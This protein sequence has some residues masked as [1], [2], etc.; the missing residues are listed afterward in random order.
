MRTMRRV[1]VHN[2]GPRPSRQVRAIL[3]ATRH[4]GSETASDPG[5]PCRPAYLA[6]HR[7][8]ELLE[9]A[10][11]MWSMM[12]KCRLC[13][14]ECGAN[15]LQGKR[16]FCG[17]T[18]TTLTVSS[19]HPHFG[20]ERPLVGTNG[21]GTIFFSHC[22]LR[23]VFCQNWEISMQGCGAERSVEDLAGMMLWLQ[24]IGCHNI[25]LVTPTHYSAH[26][27]KALDLAA[28][29]DLRLPVVY[30][31]SGWERLEILKL[32]DGI[33]DIY[34][35]DFK[36]WDSG[37]ASTYS[38]GADSYPGVTAE[39]IVEMQRQIGSP[40]Y[41]AEGVMQRG[42]I[43]RHLVMPNTVSGSEQIMEW[44][45]KNMKKDIYINIMAQYRPEYKAH[46]YPDIAR[47][48]TMAEYA[49]VVEKARKLGL[50]NL[51][52]HTASLMQF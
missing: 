20:E 26:I 41:T 14:R 31:T 44:I 35:P 45:A 17:T 25:N 10:R 30:N 21:S 15:R 6:L 23:C 32:L 27:L 50:T 22:S 9:R 19:F 2:S 29:R 1:N 46:Q 49:S 28:G 8:G 4:S 34:M 43:V 33:V 52:V 38:S 12:G 24:R 5:P 51:D 13:P 36:Y 7:S 16:G 37:M 39:A 11:R 47:K 40:Q 42:I 3:A 18:G 48:I